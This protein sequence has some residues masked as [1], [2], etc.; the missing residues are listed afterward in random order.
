LD[1]SFTFFI[2]E[3]LFGSVGLDKGKFVRVEFEVVE[4]WL[5]KLSALIELLPLS[6]PLMNDLLEPAALVLNLD[7]LHLPEEVLGLLLSGDVKH[8]HPLHHL[9]FISYNINAF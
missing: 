6:L 5:L 3:R 8:A 1:L 2:E 7:G 4:M 9:F